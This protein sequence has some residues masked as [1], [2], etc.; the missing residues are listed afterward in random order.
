MDDVI[1]DMQEVGVRKKDTVDRGYWKKMIRFGNPSN[2][3][4]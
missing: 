2:G 1:E 4:M 3:G